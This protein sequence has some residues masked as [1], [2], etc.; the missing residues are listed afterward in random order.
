MAKQKKEVILGLAHLLVKDEPCFKG[1]SEI[2]KR[3]R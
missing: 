3:W 2:K 1:Y